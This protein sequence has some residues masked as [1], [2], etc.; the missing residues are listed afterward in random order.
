[1][2]ELTN[3]AIY[4]QVGPDGNLTGYH[5]AANADGT[6]PEAVESGNYFVMTGAH[7]AGDGYQLTGYTTEVDAN[8]QVFGATRT[9]D[10]MASIGLALAITA[11][12]GVAWI[13]WFMRMEQ[14][15]KKVD[16]R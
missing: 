4:W 15:R 14:K 1:M 16:V 8:G 11:A 13:S 6:I 5:I 12:A 10:N 3:S 9:K 2:N 7:Q